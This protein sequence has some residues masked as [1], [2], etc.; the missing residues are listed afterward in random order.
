MNYS[1]FYGDVYICTV[2]YGKAKI[3]GVL[4]IEEEKEILKR[5]ERQMKE[6]NYNFIGVGYVTIKLNAY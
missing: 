4:S 6:C 5:A 2:H 3:L 1:I